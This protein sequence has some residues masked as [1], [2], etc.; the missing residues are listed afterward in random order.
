MFWGWIIQV[1]GLPVAFGGLSPQTLLVL[2][3]GLGSGPL[4]FAGQLR[5]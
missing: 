2:A 3:A 4:D 1:W 5:P